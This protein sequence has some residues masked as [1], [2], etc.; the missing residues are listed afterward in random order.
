MCGIAGAIWTDDARPVDAA[1]LARM[2]DVLAHRGPDDR[3][4]YATRVQVG[5]AAGMSVGLGHRRLSIIDLAGGHQP[6][7]N[8]DE[9][10]WVTFNGEIYNFAELRQR[11]EG[12]GHHFRTTSDTEVLVH[13]YE[14]EGSDFL[15]HLN[16]MFALAIW[17][18]RRGELLLARD[19][20]GEK[21]L[22]Y[23]H[24]PGRLL[25]AS[26][27]K[28]LLAVPGAPRQIDPHAL[29]C[30]LALHYVPHP[31][32]IFAG[33]SKLP[34]A[35]WVRF[36][37]DRF[38]T[39]C[40][41]QPDFNREVARPWT[42]DVAAVRELLTEAVQM[43]M[44]SDVPLGAF[45]SGGVDSS[46]VVALMQ[47]ARSEPVRTFS[48]GFPVPEYD[49]THYARLVA[50]HLGTEHEE[51]RVTPDA[52]SI[53]PKL[54]WHYD[55][56]FS[57][58]SAIP[59]YYVAQQTR[60]HVTVALTGDGG[61]ELF[62]GYPRYRAVALGASFDRLPAP[63]RRMLAARFWQNLPAG[64]SQRS[65]LRRFKRLVGALGE[66]PGRR[67]FD[68]VSVFSEQ[69]RAELYTD[70]YLATLPDAD[71]Y[72]FIA[73][74]L[75]RSARRDPVTAASLADAVTY[76]PCDL[77]TKVDIASMAHSLEC[78]APFLDHRLVELAAALPLGR[79]YRRGRGKRILLE[80]FG[81]LLPPEILRRGKMGFGV[82]LDHW[83]R[84][85][86]RDYTREVLLDPATLG[87]GFFRPAAVTRL[88]EDH[89]SG[90]FDH[91]Y[92]L[93]TLLFFELW[94]RE[95]V[96]GAADTAR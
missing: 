95:W 73:T 65:K 64:T 57:D 46:I 29:D 84:H 55:E 25:F 22:F 83:F 92:R 35:H 28:G 62:A 44:V 71:P 9:S 68:W 69:A 18:A 5:N 86:L 75:A 3:G 79:K 38:E 85:E 43:R 96:D 23:R 63:L 56:P 91:S 31:L 54:V 24:E 61:D 17:D 26:E 93:W 19:R 78:R 33:Y 67:Y 13:L 87:R 16:G 14:D 30:Y 37:R 4:T 90:C 8:E 72:E 58:S 82:P 45:L 70:D 39:G 51:F 48:I 88:V 15:R 12:A 53:L 32:S 52:V 41:W 89:V 7:A 10:V 1:T 60:A 42:D 40:Y 49:E 21:P 11:L 27:L 77:M 2:T 20:L 80:A 59:T 94:Q 76:L 34:P 81:H 66:S 36:G 50:K 47:Q 6:L 74:A